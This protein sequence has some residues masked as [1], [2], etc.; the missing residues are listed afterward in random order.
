MKGENAS[1]DT[2]NYHFYFHTQ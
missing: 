1:T 2:I